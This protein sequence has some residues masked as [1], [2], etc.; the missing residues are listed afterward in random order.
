[1][2]LFLAV[3]LQEFSN[4]K[5]K[6]K[7]SGLTKF[8]KISRR[9]KE[10]CCRSK[11]K[12]QDANAELKSDE[13]QDEN[14]DSKDE[15]GLSDSESEESENESESNENKNEKQNERKDEEG[16][17]ARGS[18]PEFLDSNENESRSGTCC[19]FTF[20]ICRIHYHAVYLVSGGKNKP[21]SF[22]T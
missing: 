18:S 21:D 6:K 9:C 11:E 2:N 14:E 12:V 4:D 3:I 8:E 16:D 13:E 7:P 5:I 10:L 20:G 22:T 15:N 1:M 19:A 17:S